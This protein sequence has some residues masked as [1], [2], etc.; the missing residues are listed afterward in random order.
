MK[1]PTGLV[2]GCTTSSTIGETA[3]SSACPV[4]PSLTLRPPSPSVALA[5]LSSGAKSS[6]SRFSAAVSVA[7]IACAEQST[8]R[9]DRRHA[10]LTRAA[11]RSQTA[12]AAIRP[13][14]V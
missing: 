2:H 6:A 14:V 1:Q 5:T 11:C 13:S 7:P 10:P 12:A 4:S 3:P 8:S 9:S